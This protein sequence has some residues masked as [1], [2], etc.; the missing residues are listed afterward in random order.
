MHM[1][2]KAMTGA[3]QSVETTSAPVVEFSIYFHTC[4]TGHE[5]SSWRSDWRALS[6]ILAENQNTST[7]LTQSKGYH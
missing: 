2:L 6:N 5:D 3:A 4:F 1:R 7:S